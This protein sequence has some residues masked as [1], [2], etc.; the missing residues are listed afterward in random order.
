M[1]ISFSTKD[2]MAGSFGLSIASSDVYD[3]WR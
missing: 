3:S 1:Q 2:L